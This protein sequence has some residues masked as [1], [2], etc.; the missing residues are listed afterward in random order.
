MVFLAVAA[1]ALALPGGFEAR[2]ED[3]SLVSVG[4]W[5]EPSPGWKGRWWWHE[6]GG[7]AWMKAGPVQ[8]GP[9]TVSQGA[10][11]WRD[12]G[13]G[14]TLSSGH[15][16]VGV[17]ADSWGFWSVQG[18]EEL[19]AGA[20]GRLDAGPWSLAI[21]ADRTWKL[22]PEPLDVSPWTNRARAGLVF[23]TASSRVG[24]EATGVIPAQGEKTWWGRSRGAASVR[25]WSVD[26]EASG[27][28]DRSDDRK[29]WA[30]AATLSWKRWFAGWA[31]DAD[32]AEGAAKVGAR[33]SGLEGWA[34]WGPLA[35]V[36][37]EGG[38]DTRVM[39]VDLGVTAGTRFAGGRWSHRG[40]ASASGRLDRGRW[41]GEWE[42]STGRGP[43]TQTVTAAWR[44]PTLE[45]EARWKIQGF[46]LG[47]IGPGT[48][49]S[50]GMKWYF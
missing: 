20:Q 36:E 1:S 21:G 5:W 12:W 35:G 14:T 16:G 26:V 46:R 30:A 3:G 17:D 31:G 10:E 25:S 39:A 42:V 4:S 41:S 40:G 47:W 18:P 48:T 45:A 11:G 50:L 49:F 32:A 23:D 13:P 38:A 6:A 28:T 43:T 22:D 2:A 29:L 27:G 7:A 15:W 9:L 37:A 44:E 24:V 19:E 8:V 34:S 33:G